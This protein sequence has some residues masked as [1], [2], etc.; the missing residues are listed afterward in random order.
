MSARW[1]KRWFLPPLSQKDQLATVHN[2]MPLWRFQNPEVGLRHSPG[3]Q[4]PGNNALEEQ[5][6]TLHHRHWLQG[7]HCS[8]KG[9]PGPLPSPDGGREFRVD[10]QLPQSSRMPPRRATCPVLSPGNPWRGWCKSVGLDDW[11]SAREEAGDEDHSTQHVGLGWLCSFW[12]WHLCRELSQW[13]CLSTE[14]SCGPLWPGNSVGSSASVGSPAKGLPG[15]RS[16]PMAPPK[17]SAKPPALT[18]CWA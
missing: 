14:L 1:W 4:K 6:F 10:I 5:D 7:R 12:W 15:Y 18:V 9:P 17:Q 3:S 11:G 16:H 8:V 2:K 13:S